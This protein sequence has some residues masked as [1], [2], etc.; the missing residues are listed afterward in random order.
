MDV[1]GPPGLQGDDDTAVCFQAETRGQPHTGRTF[2][3]MQ[4]ETSGGL[5]SETIS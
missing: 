4:S 3:E 5:A 1:T 2:A